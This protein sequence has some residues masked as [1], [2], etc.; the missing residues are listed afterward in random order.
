MAIHTPKGTLEFE[1]AVKRLE[2]RGYCTSCEDIQILVND[3]CRKCTSRNSFDECNTECRIYM[4]GQ[5]NDPYTKKVTGGMYTSGI[6]K[7]ADGKYH[8]SHKSGGG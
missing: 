7:S 5:G 4:I 3:C 6:Y 2:N 8:Y 1:E